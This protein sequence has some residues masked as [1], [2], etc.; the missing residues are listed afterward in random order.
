MVAHPVRDTDGRPVARSKA[1]DRISRVALPFLVFGSC[2][3]SGILGDHFYLSKIVAGL[4]Y[5]Q[6][7]S[8]RHLLWDAICVCIALAGISSTLWLGLF[9]PRVH[10]SSH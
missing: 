7:P 5:I 4:W 9:W 3:L 6:L 1:M 8:A 2:G 10:S